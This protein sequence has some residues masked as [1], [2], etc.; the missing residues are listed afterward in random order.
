M[1]HD[2]FDTQD[3]DI[4]QAFVQPL[5]EVF[6]LREGAAAVFLGVWSGVIKPPC[7]AVSVSM[8]ATLGTRPWMSGT[9][10][11]PGFS[12]SRVKLYANVAALM[13]RAL[14]WQPG[15]VG[16]LARWRGINAPLDVVQMTAIWLHGGIFFSWSRFLLFCLL[17]W[18]VK[19]HCWRKR[20]LVQGKKETTGKPVT[21][22]Q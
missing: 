10:V 21:Q 4:R 1:L 18:D 15:C 2:Q 16:A 11:F 17:E 9:R 22:I 13:A 20:E 19:R 12:H 7:F 8:W 3:R 6:E 14:S 5:E